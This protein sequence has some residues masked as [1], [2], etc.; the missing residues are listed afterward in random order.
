M[1]KKDVKI[2]N[3]KSETASCEKIGNEKRRAFIKRL[4]KIGAIAPVAIVLHDTSVNVA[5]A[6]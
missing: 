6:E 5:S 1:P 2:K 4:A 3:S